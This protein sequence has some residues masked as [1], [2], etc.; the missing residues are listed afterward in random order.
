MRQCEDSKTALKEKELKKTNYS[1]QLQ[2]WQHKG[3]KCNNNLEKEMR[4][5]NSCMGIS[6]NKLTKFHTKRPE[7]S[8]EKESSL[9]AAQ[10]KAITIC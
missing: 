3:K 7:H 2:H 4:R 8:Y 1:D 10:N 6:N 9:I 5:K